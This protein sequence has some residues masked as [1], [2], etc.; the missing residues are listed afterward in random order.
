M[1][2]FRMV[3]NENIRSFEFKDCWVS[4]MKDG[5]INM[6]MDNGISSYGCIE[7]ASEMFTPD[8]FKTFVENILWISENI[9]L[10]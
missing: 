7:R 1:E 5:K 2:A 3:Y 4:Q 10:K 9:I 6:V 8:E